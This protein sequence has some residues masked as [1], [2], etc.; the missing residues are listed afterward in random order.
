MAVAHGVRHDVAQ[1]SRD[2]V[3]EAGPA[4]RE[5]QVEQLLAQSVG[6]RLPDRPRGQRRKMIGDAVHQSVRG[7]AER[8][9][10]TFAR[11][12]PLR[13]RHIASIGSKPSSPVGAAA[14]RVSISVV[15]ARDL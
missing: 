14:S 6:E 12:A 4:L 15:I 2:Q 8:L 13:F 5:G 3:V 9:Q 7:A 10:L 1:R 11:R